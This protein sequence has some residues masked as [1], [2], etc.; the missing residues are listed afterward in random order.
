MDFRVVLEL[1]ESLERLEARVLVV[2]PGDVADVHAVA[3]EVIEEAAAV[4]ARVDG[5][6][7]RVL[8]EA[9]LGASRRE[10]PELLDAEAVSLRLP[11]VGEAEVRHDLLGDAAAAAFGEHGRPRADV[12]ARRVVRTR[13]AIAAEAHVADA[14]ARD[15]SALDE[16]LRRGEAG[17]HVDA[18]RL[19]AGGE[20]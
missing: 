4:G 16:P 19:G 13:L 20:D 3:V 2:E 7:H 1:L 8:D 9:G 6:S 12:G 11:P 15:A 10:L 14:H 5:P 17:K 18:E